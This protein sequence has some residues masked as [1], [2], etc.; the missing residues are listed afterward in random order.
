M[1]IGITVKFEIKPGTNDAFEAGF[2][3]AA[4]VVKAQDQGCEMH[5]LRMLIAGVNAGICKTEQAFLDAEPLAPARGRGQGQ[6]A[7][8][9]V[10]GNGEMAQALLALADHALPEDAM[11]QGPMPGD[12][13]PQGPMPQGSI[14]KDA[15]VNAWRA[16]AA[17][18]IA[19]LSAQAARSPAGATLALAAQR[20]LA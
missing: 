12:A 4:A 9:P 2:L 7:F 18:V 14:P 6:G 15:M 20:L 8:T 17:L 11:P 13:L 1:A 16:R 19:S 5:K 10:T 3:K